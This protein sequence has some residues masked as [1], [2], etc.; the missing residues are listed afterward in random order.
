MKKAF[1]LQ[2]RWQFFMMML[3]LCAVVL[4]TLSCFYKWSASSSSSLFV[5]SCDMNVWPFQ[6]TIKHTSVTHTQMYATHYTHKTWPFVVCDK[7]STVFCT[8]LVYGCVALHACECV[9]VIVIILNLMEIDDVAIMKCYILPLLVC[10]FSIFHSHTR[11]LSYSLRGTL[12][13]SLSPRTAHLL[14]ILS[15]FEN[16]ESSILIKK[17][18]SEKYAKSYYFLLAQYCMEDLLL[19]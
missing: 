10:V 14:S 2:Q 4:D 17:S 11:S 7:V 13:L 15:F 12:V 3:L 18:L 19:I 16:L 9:C 5:S 8:T 1:L 6:N